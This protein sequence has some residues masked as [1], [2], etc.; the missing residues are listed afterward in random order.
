MGD[1]QLL[2]IDC[3]RLR[4]YTFRRVHTK[5]GTATCQVNWRNYLNT[6]VSDVMKRNLLMPLRDVEMICSLT[7]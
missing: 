3:I 6:Y 5:T 4:G 7:S 2:K 1:S